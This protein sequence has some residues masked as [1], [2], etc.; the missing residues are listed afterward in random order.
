ML[1]KQRQQLILEILYEKQ[2]ASVRYLSPKLGASEATIRRDI[3]KLAAEVAICEIF[4]EQAQEFPERKDVLE[5]YL[6]RSEPRCRA[7]YGEITRT[8]SRMLTQLAPEGEED[9]RIEA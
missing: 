8:G 3:T 9:Q 2:F 5:R 1:E 6:D 4:L 7:L